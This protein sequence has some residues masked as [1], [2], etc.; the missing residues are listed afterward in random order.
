MTSDESPAI[1]APLVRQLIATQFP[2]WAAL[3]VRP[4][5]ADGWDLQHAGRRDRLTTSAHAAAC[6][7]ILVAPPRWHHNGCW[8]SER[9]IGK[10]GR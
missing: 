10:L 9:A 8:R 7:R 3:A 4:V 6:S 2:R 5:D 1:D